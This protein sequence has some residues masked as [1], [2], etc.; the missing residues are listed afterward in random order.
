MPSAHFSKKGYILW[1]GNDL[2]KKQPEKYLDLATKLPQ[3]KFKMI[4]SPASGAER[5][6]LIKNRADS[7]PNLECLGFVPFNEIA[8][9][10]QGAALFISTSLREGFPNTFLQAWQF[11]T[12]VVSLNLDPDDVIKKHELGH[13]AAT[14]AELCQSVEELMGNEEKRIEMGKNAS[15]YVT[16]E[17]APERIVN[18]YIN[19]FEM[20]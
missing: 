10:F 12:P 15:N 13:C 20:L 18:Q 3:Y 1:V 7:I 11:G 6:N 19:L 16:N 4:L 9:Y 14:F 8:K 17:H 2:P 5:M